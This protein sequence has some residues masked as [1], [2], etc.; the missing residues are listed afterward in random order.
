MAS[1]PPMPGM[2]RSMMT[3]SG[4][5]ILE[6]PVGL[7]AIGRLGDDTQSRLLLQNRTIALANDGVVVDQQDAFDH[8]PFMPGTPSGT[9][10]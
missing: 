10:A 3:R 9:V 1:M 2:V 7:G 5:G 6:Q 8:P 4:R